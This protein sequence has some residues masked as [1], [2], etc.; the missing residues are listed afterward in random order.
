M[1]GVPTSTV[2]TASSEA[3]S[4]TVL[5]TNWGWIGSWPASPVARSSSPSRA[6]ADRARVSARGERP[7]V[8]SRRGRRGA[9][10]S[11]PAPHGSHVL[12]FA[13]GDTVTADL[14]IGADILYARELHPHLR[15]IFAQ[16]RAVMLGDPYRAPALE[17]FEA[18]EK[19]GWR[20][21]LAK[22]TLND[23]AVG[24]FQIARV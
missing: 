13:H 12:D 17:L 10:P 6:V 11:P 7:P 21:T 23:R 24:V 5:A 15:K 1:V 22:Y 2:N 16:G 20:V 3:S 9:A 14:I 18:M 4:L 8:A 19:D